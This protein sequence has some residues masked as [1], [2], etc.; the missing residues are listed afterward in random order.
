M[1]ASANVQRGVF[2]C[3]ENSTTEAELWTWPLEW[4]LSRTSLRGVVI[5]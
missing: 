3:P 4:G 2:S 5:G 1:H